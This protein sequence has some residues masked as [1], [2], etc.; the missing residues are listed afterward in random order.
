MRLNFSVLSMTM[1]LLSVTFLV[2]LTLFES[3]L[4]SISSVSER[5]MGF[6]LLVLP[7]IIGIV[8]GVTGIVRKESKI[9]IAWLGILLNILFALF[10]TLVLLFAG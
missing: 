6:L 8:F 7:G 9:W 2:A 4:I 5:I 1:V 3:S 10:H